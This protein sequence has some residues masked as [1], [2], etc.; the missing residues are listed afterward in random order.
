MNAQPRVESAPI[1]LADELFRNNN[2][3]QRLVSSALASTFEYR[4]EEPPMELSAAQSINVFELPVFTPIQSRP[5]EF[6]AAVQEWE[7]VVTK[8]CKGLFF[9]DLV[10]LSSNESEVSEKA[11]IS[12]D[13]IDPADLE[14]VCEGAIFRWSIGHS[15]TR[16]GEFSRKWRIYFRKA[17]PS[18]ER[19]ASTL[20]NIT[21]PDWLQYKLD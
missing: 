3:F 6:F 1:F 15:R 11:E 18:T 4:A 13:D 2:L 14:R 10:D 17:I 19:S 16:G 7:G 9:A 21:L 5:N 8:V 12:F 20:E